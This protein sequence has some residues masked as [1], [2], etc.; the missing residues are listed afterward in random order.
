MR[1]VATNTKRFDFDIW[2]FS[3][4]KREG[5]EFKDIGENNQG[6][7]RHINFMVYLLWDLPYSVVHGPVRE[8][9]LGMKANLEHDEWPTTDDYYKQAQRTAPGFL[10]R[11]ADLHASH[12][13]VTVTDLLRV[14]S[15]GYPGT[16]TNPI[17][18]SRDAFNIVRLSN[19]LKRALWDA[20]TRVDICLPFI[21][22]Q[23]TDRD[24]APEP[25][26]FVSAEDVAK[27]G[28]RI[29]HLTL[30]DLYIKPLTTYQRAAVAAF[31]M[32]GVFRPTS[33]TKG[34]LIEVTVESTTDENEPSTGGQG[35]N[36]KCYTGEGCKKENGFYC[37][38]DSQGECSA[39]G[40]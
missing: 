10:G 37:S 25:A 22:I 16:P 15:R 14:D 24:T 39:M 27:Y 3:P 18:E 23:G 40:G 11:I 21:D 8:L 7:Y 29:N 9:A 5:K 38:Y 1:E 26:K 33:Q 17:H 34:T 4:E 12:R 19:D 32:N 6:L 20:D 31:G 13:G 35:N 30:R 36:Y 2:G 28:P